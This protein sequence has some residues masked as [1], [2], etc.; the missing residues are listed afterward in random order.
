MDPRADE[1]W[2][3]DAEAR[4]RAEVPRSTE[5]VRPS[6]EPLAEDL[7]LDPDGQIKAPGYG[8]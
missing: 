8:V 4:R 1:L 7:E 3:K 6:E 2:K 5:A